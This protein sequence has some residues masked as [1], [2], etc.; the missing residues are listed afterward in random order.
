MILYEIYKVCGIFTLAFLHCLHNSKTA[1]N[2]KPLRPVVL[3]LPL[4]K[5]QDE[6]VWICVH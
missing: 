6:L 2:L 3:I 5:C 4:M 1:V